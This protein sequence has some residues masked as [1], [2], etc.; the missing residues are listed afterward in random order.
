VR[1][2]CFFIILNTERNR[3]IGRPL[4]NKKIGTQFRVIT[5]HA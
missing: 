5:A 1:V 4:K 2:V 3:R